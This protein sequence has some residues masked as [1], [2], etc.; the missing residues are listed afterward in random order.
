MGRVGV[1][2]CNGCSFCVYVFVFGL[3]LS[4]LGGR[5]FVPEWGMDWIGFVGGPVFSSIYE[6]IGR[7]PWELYLGGMVCP[8]QPM[9]PMFA[10]S[11]YSL[12]R[13]LCG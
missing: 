3:V 8:Y 13:A 10:L 5:P 6:R 11:F 12:H 1:G 2:R 7:G 4:Y 9:F